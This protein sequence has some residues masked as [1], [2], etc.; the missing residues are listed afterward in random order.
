MR[1]LQGTYCHLQQRENSG[2]SKRARVKSDIT[3][4]KSK[5]VRFKSESKLLPKKVR[6]MNLN[7]GAQTLEFHWTVPN[8][9]AYALRAK[10]L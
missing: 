5:L 9:N 3:H 10:Q 2:S 4:S 6:T 1:Q 8:S 7:N